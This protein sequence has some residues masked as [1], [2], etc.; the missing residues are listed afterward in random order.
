MNDNFTPV[1]TGTNRCKHK[2]NYCRNIACYGYYHQNISCE[3]YYLA[4]SRC[5]IL[6]AVNYIASWRVPIS[7]YFPENH[8]A[9][10]LVNRNDFASLE[11]L[12]NY[13]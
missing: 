1:S 10:K 2:V 9:N 8:T 12:M 5:N 6:S 3:I 11:P 4:G 13:Y 7:V